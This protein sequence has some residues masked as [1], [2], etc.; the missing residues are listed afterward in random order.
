MIKFLSVLILVFAFCLSAKVQII[1]AQPAPQPE[2]VKIYIVYP[3]NG[4]MYASDNVRIQV[5]VS[6][7]PLGVM[8][9]NGR[10]Q[11]LA[12]ASIGQ[13]LRVV[14]DNNQYFARSGPG[15]DPYDEDE[16]YYDAMYKFK[17]PVSL[18]QGKHFLRVFPARSYGESLKKE[19]N[20]AAAYFFIENN[21]VNQDVN[22][23]DPYITFNEPSGYARLNEK[24]PI[25]L[26]FY[27]SNC[28]LSADGY[29]VKVTIDKDVTRLISLWIP[30]YIYGLK[31]GNHTIRLRLVD[32]NLKQVPG[33][34]NDVAREF[35]VN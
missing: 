2:N 3:K 27:V 23:S 10:R 32:K 35:N 22:L 6:G 25:L 5:K 16:N 30:Y 15:V 34:F 24:D 28:Y 7:F 8:T 1:P 18:S 9:D 12:N 19:N 13:S 11:E 21:R 4:Q 31:R 20:F 17:V 29:K 26:D 33:L 14:I